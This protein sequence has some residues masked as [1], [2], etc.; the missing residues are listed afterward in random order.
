MV[1]Y[2]EFP[3]L[4]LETT[5]SV[6]VLNLKKIADRILTTVSTR[7]N[8]SESSRNLPKPRIANYR[9]TVM[10]FSIAGLELGGACTI[11]KSRRRSQAW[12][13]PPSLYHI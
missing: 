1:Y 9:L 5:K 2:L 7:Q 6:P 13:I 11:F 12:S 4:I 8:W 3:L 10:K